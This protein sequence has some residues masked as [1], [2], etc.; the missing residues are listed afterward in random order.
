MHVHPRSLIQKILVT[1]SL[2]SR[3]R[4]KLQWKLSIVS[5]QDITWKD[6]NFNEVVQLKNRSCSTLKSYPSMNPDFVAN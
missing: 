2:L 6:V 5:N 4:C 1:I 3:G